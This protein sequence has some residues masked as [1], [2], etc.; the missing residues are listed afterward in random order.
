MNIFSIHLKNRAFR[1]FMIYGPLL[2]K[3]RLMKIRKAKRKILVVDLRNL[4]SGFNIFLSKKD[5]KTSPNNDSIAA[6]EIGIAIIIP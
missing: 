1:L 5:K 6:F 3:E 2:N 4:K